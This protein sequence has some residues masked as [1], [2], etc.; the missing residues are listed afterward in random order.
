MDMK[1][2]R[3]IIMLPLFIFLVACYETDSKKDAT[4][5]GHSVEDLIKNPSAKVTHEDGWTIV[6]K[7]ENGEIITAVISPSRTDWLKL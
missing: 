4:A 6:S 3:Y 2:L 5:A 1:H 7:I